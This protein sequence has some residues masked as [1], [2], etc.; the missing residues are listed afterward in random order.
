MLSRLHLSALLLLA[1]GIWG[2]ML[3]VEGVV[4]SGTWFRPFSTVV[5]VLLFFLVV[6]DLWAW[7][8]RFLQGWF[9]PRPDIRGTWR[10][11]LKSNW[12]DRAPNSAPKTIC[13]YLIVRQTYS[14]LSL[15]M[16]TLESTS[17]LVSAEITRA[18]DGLYKVAGV[19]RNEPKLSVRDR[20]PIHYGAI[21]LDIHG[22]PVKSLVGHYWTDRDTR[23]ELISVSHH[24]AM[25]SSV[26]VAQSLFLNSESA[27]SEI[28]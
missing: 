21:V 14:T 11:E 24:P 22:D 7:R 9:V 4:I 18:G 3:I 1:S 8:L 5:G 28:K 2:L 20:S 17:E 16:I 10:I 6:F 26:D 15:R 19:Y 27:I 25:A 13:A 23:G 12:T